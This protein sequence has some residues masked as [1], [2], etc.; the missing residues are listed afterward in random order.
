[1][2]NDGYNGFGF[3]RSRRWLALAFVT[4]CRMRFIAVNALGGGSVVAEGCGVL[5]AADGAYLSLDAGGAR[6]VVVPL[7]L[8]T[9]DP[10]RG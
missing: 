4:E 9:P 1:M 2:G 3:G 6:E 5:V 8:V 7:A 10:L